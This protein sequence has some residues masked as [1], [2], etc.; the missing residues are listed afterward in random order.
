MDITMVILRLIH[1]FGGAYWFGSGML[2]VFVV[3]PFAKTVGAEGERF[4]GRLLSQSKYSPYM[5]ISAVLT[6]LSGVLM[7]WRD[8]GGLQAAWIA[9]N[10]GIAL[11]I[12]GAAGIGAWLVGML[13]HAPAS[14]RLAAIA[15]EMGN[16]APTPAQIE[17][18]RAVQG[19][20]KQGNA[21]ETVLMVV[22]L[23][24]MAV[25]RYV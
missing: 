9:T 1:I 21:W 13:V 6:T 8:S 19:K 12:G 25:A 20:L 16:G 10:A 15:K 11:T 17:Q 23:I 22:T 5:G 14:A 18:I 7:Y 4:V 2:A 3:E 24:G